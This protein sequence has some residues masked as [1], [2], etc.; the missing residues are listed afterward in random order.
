MKLTPAQARGELGRR[1]RRLRRGQGLNGLQLARRAGVGGG[2]VWKLEQG[3]S[4]AS[5]AHVLET[6]SALDVDA[7]VAAVLLG[8]ALVAQGR[9]LSKRARRYLTRIVAAIIAGGAQDLAAAASRLVVRG[10]GV[11]LTRLLH[12]FDH[13]EALAK[14]WFA[15]LLAVEKY[16]VGSN[17]Y[18]SRW[19]VL[20]DGLTVADV[21]SR[22]KAG[23]RRHKRIS[24]DAWR[25]FLLLR[26]QGETVTRAYRRVL[27][28]SRRH[29]WSWPL[30]LKAIRNRAAAFD[31][32][33]RQ[34]MGTG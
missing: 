33:Q 19:A 34:W 22:R 10:R 4:G 21:V 12:L 27:F 30:S 16:S 9:G 5:I 25:T 7:P 28:L 23:K 3:E 11:R 14:A 6:V 31:R 24:P 8:L 1:L 18:V 15:A 13:D 29:G 17:H 2:Y 20:P 32:E 26:E